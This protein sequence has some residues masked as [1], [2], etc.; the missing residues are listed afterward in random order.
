MHVSLLLSDQS[1]CAPLA[2]FFFFTLLMIHLPIIYHGV[3]NFKTNSP[4]NFKIN[5][6]VVVSEKNLLLKNNESGV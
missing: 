5:G 4:A 1:P 6:Q 3:F 2:Q